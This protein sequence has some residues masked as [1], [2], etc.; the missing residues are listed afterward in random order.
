M[1]DAIPRWATKMPIVAGCAECS[2]TGLES[3][4]RCH[5]ANQFVA[6]SIVQGPIDAIDL[7]N[8]HST[9]IS[10]CSCRCAAHTRTVEHGTVSPPQN[11]FAAICKWHIFE[12]Y[13]ATTTVTA[14]VLMIMMLIMISTI[15]KPQ[16]LP[17]KRGI[18]ADKGPMA[19]TSWPM[20]CDRQTATIS[21]GRDHPDRQRK[22][23]CAM[24]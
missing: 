1:L 16:L 7:P 10:S 22:Y 24:G 23:V 9:G 2:R 5:I 3:V 15:A 19:V 21:I 6:T 13:R 4:I 14:T 12:S 8:N 20:R 17:Q 18:L 11:L